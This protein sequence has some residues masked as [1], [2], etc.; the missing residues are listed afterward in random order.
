MTNKHDHRADL[1]FMN[2][3]DAA[4]RLKPSS[5]SSLMLWTII[6]LVGFIFVW[7][8]VSEIEVITRGQGQVVP[9]LETQLVQSLEGGILAELN[10]QEGDR[11]EKG[12]VLARIENVAFA[13]EERGIE[14]QSLALHLKQAR[15]KAEIDGKKFKIPDEMRA[16]NTKL[17]ANEV[18]LYQSRQRELK[19]AQGIADEAFAKANANFREI[20]ATIN[21]L[22]ESKRLLSQQLKITRNLVSK[23]AMPKVEALTQEREFADVRGNFNAAIERKKALQADLNMA[24]RQK[25][26]ALNKFRSQSLGEMS[27]VETKLSAIKESLTAA[28]DKV[29]RTELRATA[30]GVIKTINQKTKLYS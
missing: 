2:E 26:D 5:Q 10:V 27:E 13:S 6:A 23:N 12:Q 21:R 4:T 14:A 8:F 30:D 17:A 20:K 24:E 22:S 7:S 9:S 25:S 11:V 29:D 3:I 18:A 15:L 1:D 19:N 28:G 16:K